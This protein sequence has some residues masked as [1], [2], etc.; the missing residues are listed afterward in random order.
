M[1][2][3]C[4]LFLSFTLLLHFSHAQTQQELQEYPCGHISCAK[5]YLCYD[6]SCVNECPEVKPFPL[7]MDNIKQCFPCDGK[8]PFYDPTGKNA[9]SLKGSCNK[10]CPSTLMYYDT[11]K[12]CHQSCP[13]DEPYY[14]QN[15]YSCHAK[16]P[17]ETPTHEKGKYNCTDCPSE[18]RYFDPVSDSCIVKCPP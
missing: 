8:T 14:P 11:N 10:T 2:K 7:L 16:C 12:I 9:F 15:N 1:T 18:N 6:G 17:D 4:L 3:L 5:E 13:S